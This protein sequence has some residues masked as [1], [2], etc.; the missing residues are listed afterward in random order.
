MAPARA[1]HMAACPGSRML[2]GN[3]HKAVPVLFHAGGAVRAGPA[4]SDRRQQ[5]AEHRQYEQ[6]RV[7]ASH[8]FR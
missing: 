8:G 1:V 6:S 3:A 7:G 5:Q 4:R 2:A